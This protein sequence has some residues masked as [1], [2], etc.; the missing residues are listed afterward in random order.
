M[1]GEEG[2]SDL[3][4]AEAAPRRFS[5]FPAALRITYLG[6]YR[7]TPSVLQRRTGKGG[8]RYC[9]AQ[10]AVCG[11]MLPAGQSADRSASPSGV[12]ALA[13][14]ES[15]PG[16]LPI[17]CKFCRMPRGRGY[18]IQASH[19]WHSPF[20]SHNTATVERERNVREHY[21]RLPLHAALSTVHR[22]QVQLP[23]QSWKLGGHGWPP[24]PQRGT[25]LRRLG[26][27]RR[28]RA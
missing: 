24:R 3:A 18:L 13:A 23:R 26:H 1:G 7:G 14:R 21:V 9:S 16:S 25:S 28:L 8:R 10:I 5:L 11:Y 4:L 6:T 15:T 27:G 22:L 19:F 12:Q 2:E 20:L 17:H